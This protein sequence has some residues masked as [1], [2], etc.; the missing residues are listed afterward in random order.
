M[1]FLPWQFVSISVSHLFFLYY[2]CVKYKFSLYFTKWCKLM[3]KGYILIEKVFLLIDGIRNNGHV[4]NL[5]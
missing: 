2:L 3:D 4:I 1:C 5:K